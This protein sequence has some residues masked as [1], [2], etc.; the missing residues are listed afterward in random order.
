MTQI[1]IIAGSSA[2]GKTSLA[3]QL[4]LWLNQRYAKD[5]CEIIAE[6][7]YYHDLTHL[8][9]DERA[10]VNFDHPC[11]LDHDLLLLHLK[12]IKQGLCVDVP[13]YCY[14]THQRE[15]IG[16]KTQALPFLILEG[17]HTFYEREIKSLS[18]YLIFVNTDADICL[19]RR[20]LR[21]INERARTLESVIEQYLTTVKPMFEKFVAPKKTDANLLVAG[22]IPIKD[23]LERAIEHEKFKQLLKNHKE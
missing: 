14:K 4:Q 1:I 13:S 10:K 15:S 5:V 3:T 11:S 20:I 19:A 22:S 18:G 2:S 9:F 17:I 12:Q 23:M 7:S 8:S 6:D 16:K 21:D